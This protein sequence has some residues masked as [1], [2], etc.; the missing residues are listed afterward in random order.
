M[1]CVYRHRLIFRSGLTHA[2]SWA[3][4]KPTRMAGRSGNGST[5]VLHI[6]SGKLANTPVATAEMDTVFNRVEMTMMGDGSLTGHSEIVAKGATEARLRQLVASVPS[7]QCDKFVTRWLGSNQKGKGTYSS[8]EPNDL[9]KPFGLSVNFEI[10]DVVDVQSPGAFPIPKGF[11]YQ[12]IHRAISAGEQNMT[13][14]RTP[15]NAAPA[16]ISMR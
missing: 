1:S 16:P 7:N 8:N 3:A 10:K 13:T 15:S 9:S 12:D 4:N 2:K 14:R 11:F 5:P 6:A